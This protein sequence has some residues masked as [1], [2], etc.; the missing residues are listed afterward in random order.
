MNNGLEHFWFRQAVENSIDSLIITNMDGRVVFANRAWAA[1]HGY[2]TQELPGMQCSAFFPA[3]ELR[4]ADEIRQKVIQNGAHEGGVDHI[5]KDGTFFRTRMRLS[6]IRDQAGQPAGFLAAANDMTERDKME[7]VNETLMLLGRKFL[8]TRT[9]RETAQ[10]IL[11]AAD[12]LIGWD[13]AYV[14][15]FHSHDKHLE[16]ILCY[17]LVDGRR[18]LI[19]APFTVVLM[20]PVIRRVFEHGPQL[21]LRSPDDMQTADDDSVLLSGTNRRS[22]SRMFALIRYLDE[23]I[24]MISIQSYAMNAYT[25]NDL[26]LLQSLADYC[27]GALE[28]AASDSRARETLK[29][30]S[31]ITERKRAESALRELTNDLTTA[32][33]TLARSSRMKD[34]FLASMNHELRTPLTAVLGLSEALALE[35]YGPLNKKQINSLNSIRDSG[36]RLLALINDILDLSK[37]ESGRA[38]LEFEPVEIGEL[39]RSCLRLISEPAQKKNLHASY[40]NLGAIKTIR[41]DKRRIKQILLNLLDNAVKFTPE[42]GSIG[43]NVEGDSISGKASFIVWDTGIGIARED[44]DRIF[45]P[46]LQLDSSLSRQYSGTGLGLALVKRTTEMHEGTVRIESEPGKGSRFTVELPWAPLMKIIGSQS[47]EP[48][49]DAPAAGMSASP[50]D[51]PLILITENNGVI[52]GMLAE[53]LETSGC[54]AQTA[55]N[56]VAAVEMAASLR[57]SLILM[58]IRMPGMDGIEAVR[59]MRSIPQV[60]ATPVVAVTALAM[61]GD[62]EECLKA[63]ASDYISKPFDLLELLDMIQKHIKEYHGK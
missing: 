29:L 44:F 50:D 37:I 27:G 36:Q 33:A 15:T 40:N 23:N 9:P 35:V 16:M 20:T 17:D 46:F 18:T 45:D 22:A 21:L 10:A 3:G 39:C 51:R 38:E 49:A 2:E 8:V 24:G 63:G 25:G 31:E 19:A 32:N 61:P 57:P 34:E 4:Y 54:R 58:D 53:Y 28:R 26:K 60:S 52:T 7:R 41:A 30:R 56:G 48:S 5:R 42:G 43:L 6:L 59:A 1:M 47:D 13:A 55:D 62:R 14:D 11:D 12:T